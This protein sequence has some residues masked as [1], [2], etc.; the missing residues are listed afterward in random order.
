[1]A[2]YARVAGQ[3]GQ[4][5]SPGTVHRI[6]VVLHRALAPGP[7]VG[8]DLG[9]SGQTASPPSCE[10]PPI[11]PPSPEEVVRLLSPRRRCRS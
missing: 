6:H 5:L 1:M 9:Q 3:Y 8:M 11:Y 4:P 7:S 10:P 2:I